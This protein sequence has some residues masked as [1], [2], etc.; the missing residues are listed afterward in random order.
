MAEEDRLHHALKKDGV[1]TDGC[2]GFKFNVFFKG[3]LVSGQAGIEDRDI[4]H[5]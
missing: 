3:V 5:S 1:R 4:Y 2:F